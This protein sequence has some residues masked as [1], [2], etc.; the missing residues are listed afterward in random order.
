MQLVSRG[1]ERFK[2][3]FKRPRVLLMDIEGT[4]TTV[5]FVHKVLFP[6]AAAHLQQFLQTK[7]HREEVRV[8][9]QEVAVLLQAENRAYAT[10]EDK[11]RGM[12]TWI[13][14]DKKHKPAQRY[15]GSHLEGWLPE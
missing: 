4:T 1:T 11:I 2:M 13:D 12:L 15:P 9:L 6:Y 8:L 3:E 7:G 5:E 10:L 14:E